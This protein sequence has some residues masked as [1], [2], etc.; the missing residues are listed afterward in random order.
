MTFT[1]EFGNRNQ[2][3][4]HGDSSC[5]SHITDTLP[6]E[7]TFVHA[8]APWDPHW[9]PDQLPGNVLEWEWGSM[10]SHS[11]WRFDLVV[12]ITDTVEGGDVITNAIEAYGDSPNDVEPFWDNNV[13]ELPITIIHPKFE[14]G[15]VYESSCVAGMPV[16]Y[17]LTVINTGTEA[18]TNVVLSDTLPA[19]LNNVGTDG[20]LVSG[21]VTWS[22]A[23]IAP[24]G[25]TASSWFSGTLPCTTG[26]VTNDNYRVVSSDEGVIS[27][28]G[29]PVVFGVAA[30][31]VDAAFDVSTDAVVVGTTIHFTGT[32][33]TDGTPIVEWEWDF[34]DG[35][36][37]VFT[38]NASHT[39]L[40]DGTFTPLLTVTD[41][42]GYAVVKQDLIEIVVAPH[43]I[44]L[45]LVIKGA[46]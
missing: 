21:D 30:P 27:L 7:M 26:S 38:Q 3:P 15:K 18:G 14:V 19:P 23:S 42:C 4:W 5:G 24:Y 17:T 25:G 41:T 9:I 13:F 36:A 46:P 10:G 1:V 35:S 45:P 6:P 8:I 2:W 16:T 22:F 39:Y 34:D 37:H 29:A 43:M 20:T 31:A 33:T 12:Q 32:G 40:S 44:Y 11:I 28:P